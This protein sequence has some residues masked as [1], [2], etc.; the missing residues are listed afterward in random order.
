MRELLLEYKQSRDG[1][2][3]MLKKLG[4]NERDKDDKTYINSMIDSVTDIIDW[5]DTGI[6]PFYPAGIDR[7]HAYDVTR[8]SNMDI[9]PEITEQLEPEPVELTDEQ[10]RIITRIFQTLTDRERDC[11]MLHHVLFMTQAEVANEL[12]IAR[13]TA[14]YHIENARDKIKEIVNPSKDRAI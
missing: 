10:K 2:N 11:F 8:L 9:I 6:N 3:E 7:R 14:Q 1:L 13:T 4:D 12:G 5:L